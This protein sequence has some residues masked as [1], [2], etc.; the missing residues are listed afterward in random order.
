MPVR[1]SLFPPMP[2]GMTRRQA[3]HQFAVAACGLTGAV[4]LPGWAKAQ[5]AR[6]LAASGHN[7]LLSGHPAEA[8]TALTEAAKADPANGWIWNLLGR[9][10]YEKGD[11]RRAADSFLTALKAD[12]GDGYARMM[13]DILSQHPLSPATQA[14]RQTKPK[15][16]RPSHLEEQARAERQA[17]TAGEETSELRFICIDPGHGGPE[18]GVMGESGLVEKELTLDMAKRL[19]AQLEQRGCRVLLTRTQ[20]YAVPLWARGALAALYGAD[21]FVSLHASAG[22]PNSGGFWA[23]SYAPS[24]S[25]TLAQT[26]A[27]SENGVLRF[28]RAQ[29]PHLPIAL[30]SGLLDSWFVRRLGVVS[31]Q[32]AQSLAKAVVLHRIAPG[33]PQAAEGAQSVQAGISEQSAGAGQAARRSPATLTAKKTNVAQSAPGVVK[34]TPKA[35]TSIGAAQF[36]QSAEAVQSMQAG[37]ENQAAQAPLAVLKGL[38]VPG[39]LLEMGFLTNPVEEAALKD[40]AY[41]QA[42]AVEL[43]RALTDRPR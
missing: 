2:A 35:K 38:R 40:G 6:D 23:C 13:L 4:L 16:R 22:L 29:P 3:L 39:V 26:V 21:L 37:R 14:A 15:S 42:L 30:A 5:N 33:V 1:T 31:A 8:I 36:T 28:E 12:P 11:Y 24:P 25:D 43:A 18:Q 7:L 41:R 19:A 10:C 27:E 20:D 17:F 32:F 34:S 9:A